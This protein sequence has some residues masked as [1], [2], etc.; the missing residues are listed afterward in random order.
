MKAEDKAVEGVGAPRLVRCSSFCDYEFALF[1]DL[2]KARDL[3]P[4]ALT[5]TQM[6]E[7]LEEILRV[8]EKPTPEESQRR[9][10]FLQEVTPERLALIR[11]WIAKYRGKPHEP[12][13]E[14]ASEEQTCPS[15]R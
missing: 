10:E 2:A 1:N 3:N 7:I 12:L 8:A 13:G 14:Q 15:S 5:Q 9:K 11:Q 4:C 6:A